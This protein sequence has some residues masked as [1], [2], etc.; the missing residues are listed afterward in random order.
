MRWVSRRRLAVAALV[1]AAAVQGCVPP[2]GPDEPRNSEELQRS[3]DSP[4]KPGGYIV[5]PDVAE[6]RA[7]PLSMPGDAPTEDLIRGGKT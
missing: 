3:G 1:A 5:V 2:V 4:P 6:Q 7:S